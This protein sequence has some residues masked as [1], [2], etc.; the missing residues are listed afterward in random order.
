MAVVQP[1]WKYARTPSQPPMIDEEAFFGDISGTREEILEATYHALC[2]HGY[3]GL[4]IG[5]IGDHFDK[6]QSLIYHHY[7]DK[8]GLLIDLLGYLLEQIE[9]Q[10]PFPEEPPEEYIDIVV[11]EIFDETGSQGGAFTQAVIELRT[12]AAHDEEYYELFRRS[13]NF[14]RKQLTQI[15]RAGVDKGVFDVD[16]PKESAALFQTVLIGVQTEYLT[17]DTQTIAESKAEFRRYVETCLR[18]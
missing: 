14:I 16:E 5:K 10:V 13:D 4:T 7:D 17:A 12:Q 18:A 15:I 11:D 2:E 9:R 1:N 8:D 6:S 3:A